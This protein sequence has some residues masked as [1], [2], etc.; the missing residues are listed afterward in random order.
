MK[1]TVKTFPCFS[2][3]PVT[4]ESWWQ[5]FVCPFASFHLSVWYQTILLA[6]NL[7]CGH[8]FCHFLFYFEIALIWSVL[9]PPIVCFPACATPVFRE[10]FCKGSFPLRPKCAQC[11]CLFVSKVMAGSMETWKL[12]V[13]Q[14]DEG[15]DKSDH[16]EWMWLV[17][18]VVRCVLCLRQSDRRSRIIF[19]NSTWSRVH[20]DMNIFTWKHEHKHVITWTLEHMQRSKDALFM[21]LLQ[22]HD[23]WS[24]C[25]NVSR[26]APAAESPV[27]QRQ[28]ITTVA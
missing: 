1:P 20:V 25:F 6:Q 5:C 7:L 13:P 14:P 24:A 12:P 28:L 3:I 2:F 9:L 21:H 16:R 11:C 8:L 22:S 26:S 4:A 27:Y 15:G 10:V 23:L 17:N 19:C 18:Q